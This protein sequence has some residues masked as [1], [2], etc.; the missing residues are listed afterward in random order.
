MIAVVV[1][2]QLAASLGYYAV[3]TH[4][5]AHLRD[6]VGLLAGTIGLILGVRIAVQ[7]ALFLPVGALTDLIGAPRVGVLA[8]VLRT[9][10]FALLGTAGGP[11]GLLGAAVLLGTGGALFHPA[12]Q[13][14]LAGTAPARRDRGFAVYVITGQI[15]AVAGPPVGLALLAAGGDG[16][17]GFGLVTA[18]AAGTWSIAALLFVLLHLGGAT[19]ARPPRNG[20]AAGAREL[21]RNVAGVLRDRTFFR[22]VVVAAPTT[23]LTEQTMT[24]VPL[25]DVGAGLTTAFLCLS[26]AVA[27]SIQPWC[28]ARG[29]AGRPRVL[30]AGLLCSTAVYVLLALLPGAG[31]PLAAGLLAA[32]VLNGLATGVFQPSVFQ[33]IT[34][35]APAARIGAYLGVYSWCSGLVVFSG[36]LGVGHLFDAGPA[37]AAT[38]LAALAAVALAAAVRCGT[39][40]GHADPISSAGRYEP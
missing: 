20:A 13:S 24:V 9:A 32:A 12:A 2:V 34:R 33:S 16:G 14:L 7:Y 37:G 5:V 22:F 4:V 18:G 21:A 35:H 30:R 27:A 39:G 23:L 19:A 1:S 38:A 29:R 31:P 11:A 36:G 15:A 26:A 3:M 28:A 6:D 17:G 8:C 40:R 25:K 10:G